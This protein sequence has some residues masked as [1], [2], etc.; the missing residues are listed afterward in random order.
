MGWGGECGLRRRVC[1]G[2]Q[3]RCRGSRGE[4]LWLESSVSSV[5]EGLGQLYVSWILGI[6]ISLLPLW[7][8]AFSLVCGQGLYPV[9]RK[10]I[11]W[12]EPVVHC[13]TD[14]VE[15]SQGIYVV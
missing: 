1:C 7:K 12:S 10:E 3:G 6:C 14:S 11:Y 4:S 8:R 13:A 9:G 15:R 5:C 2:R